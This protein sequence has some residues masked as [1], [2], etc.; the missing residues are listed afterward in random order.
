MLSL[1]AALALALAV[2]SLWLISVVI[3]DTS[4][5]DIFWGP[6]F[7]L[8]G[9]V[10]AGSRGFELGAGQWLL[11][12]LVSVWGLRLGVYLGWR[13]LGHGEDKR[14]RA[15]RERVGPHYWWLSLISVFGLQATLI[16]VI[17]MPIQTTVLAEQVPAIGWLTLV[18]AGAWLLGFAFEAIGDAQLARFKADPDNAGEVMDRG[19]WGWTRHPN[20]FGDFCL[21]WGHSLIAWSLGAPWW[22]AVAPVVMSILLMKVSGVPLLERGLRE[23]RPGYAAYAERVP[24]F[25]PRPP[26][27]PAEPEG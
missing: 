21:W 24:A 22:T 12:A 7:A 13:N 17:A 15:M 27:G 14:Y 5:V 18:G 9:W 2:I 25:F 19:L 3:R 11:L 6:G 20:Y 1:P 10:C 23:R 8:V 4:I 16:F 26:S